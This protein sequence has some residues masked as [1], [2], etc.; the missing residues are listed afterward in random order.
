MRGTQSQHLNP[1]RSAQGPATQRPRSLSFAAPVTEGLVAVVSIGIPGISSPPGSFLVMPWHKAL[2]LPYEVLVVCENLEPLQRI[3]R[4]DW[5]PPFIKNRSA[6]VLFRGAPAWFRVDSANR[7]VAGDSR[8]VLELFDFDPQG[9]LMAARLPRREGLCLP[10]WEQLQPL[11]IRES[12][13]TS[14]ATN[15]PVSKRPWTHVATRISQPHG[16]ACD[17]STGPQPGSIS[18]RLLRRGRRCSVL[19][20]QAFEISLQSCKLLTSIAPVGM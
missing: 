15:C 9:L 14:M 18:R 11:V 4:Y 2:A 13:M 7:V 10:S 3:D 12:A 16:I 1:V 8:P 20:L 17:S 19:K 6:L 5:L